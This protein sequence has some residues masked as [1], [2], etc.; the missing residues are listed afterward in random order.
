[1]AARSQLTERGFLRRFKRA[2]GTAPMEYVQI[3]RIEEAKHLLET[4]DLPLDDV[5]AEVG[6]VE[7]ASFRRLFRKMVGISPSAY[8]R[9]RLP[10]PAEFVAALRSNPI[11]VD[12]AGRKAGA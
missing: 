12:R 3:L 6:Y 11:R 10:M 5:A 9:Q 8:R 2:T 7:P 1:M 4:T